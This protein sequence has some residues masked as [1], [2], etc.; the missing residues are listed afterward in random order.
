MKTQFFVEGE[1]PEKL[2][3]IR[4]SEEENRKAR[5]RY[6]VPTADIFPVSDGK[7]ALVWRKNEPMANR[8][9]RI[10][11]AINIGDTPLMAAVRNFNR[12][13]GLSKEVKDFVALDAVGVYLMQ[14]KD[15]LG[16]YWRQDVCFVHTIVLSQEEVDAF[17]LDAKEYEQKVRLAS[18]QEVIQMV[19]GGELHGSFM[20]ALHAIQEAD[21]L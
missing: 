10:G 4:L 19:A 6:P 8:W 1:L 17:Q 12:E 14:V 20:D 7:M 5:M 11:G 16:D 9:W 15:P 13:T 21:L 18:P 3:R 2:E